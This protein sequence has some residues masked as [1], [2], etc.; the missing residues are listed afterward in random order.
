M[1]SNGQQER[2]RTLRGN[3]GQMARANA[4]NHYVG[5]NRNSFSATGTVDT[6]HRAT[7]EDIA[8]YRSAR[9]AKPSGTK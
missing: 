4:A 7:D 6:N 3:T 2:A 9:Q 8:A 5:R 1:L